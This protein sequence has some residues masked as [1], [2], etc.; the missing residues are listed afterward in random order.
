MGCSQCGVKALLLA[1]GWEAGG[2]A[3]NQASTTLRP[4]VELFSPTPVRNQD[5]LDPPQAVKPTTEM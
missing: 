2:A 3:G 5:C 4:E 1:V